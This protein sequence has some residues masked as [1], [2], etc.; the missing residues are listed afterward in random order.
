MAAVFRFDI[1]AASSY[2]APG[3]TMVTIGNLLPEKWTS[4][5][6]TPGKDDG[7]F[8]CTPVGAGQCGTAGPQA[9][10]DGTG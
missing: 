5:K 4:D 10:G 6:E 2:V 8:R 3:L 9:N 1:E 7:R